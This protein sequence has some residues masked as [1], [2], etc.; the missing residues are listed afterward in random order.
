MARI[1]HTDRGQLHECETPPSKLGSLMKYAPIDCIGHADWSAGRIGVKTR[2][3]AQPLQSR[4]VVSEKSSE[5]NAVEAACAAS[6]LFQKR[7]P[8]P[9]SGLEIY[10]NSL[11]VR[12]EYMIYDE[13]YG[14]RHLHCR[15]Y[16][17]EVK[18]EAWGCRPFSVFL[19]KSYFRTAALAESVVTLVALSAVKDRLKDCGGSGFPAM[20]TTSYEGWTLT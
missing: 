20:R 5:S 9:L 1:K 6:S 3:V 19:E 17:I 18:H 12:F 8:R 4:R 16:T 11:G 2:S 7:T 14:D 15:I 10:V 13:D